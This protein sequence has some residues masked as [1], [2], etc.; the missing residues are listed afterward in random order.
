MKQGVRWIADGIRRDAD[1]LVGATIWQ[2]TSTPVTNHDI[3]GEQIYASTD[4]S[5]IAFMRDL[6][7]YGEASELWVC[8]LPTK[9]VT[10]VSEAV[11]GFA[12]TPFLDNLYYFFDSLCLRWKEIPADGHGLPSEVRGIPNV[13]RRK[14]EGAVLLASAEWTQPVG[15]EFLMYLRNLG[16]KEARKVRLTL[17]NRQ[18]A[19]GD[20][21]AEGFV[22]R[23]PPQSEF[24]TRLPM[25]S[26]LKGWPPVLE[27]VSE[28]TQI[29]N[30]S[31]RE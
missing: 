20:I 31:T 23:I 18:E 13:L 22:E 24:I 9:R 11:G 19:G 6:S 12:S 2:L 17:R 16:R 4:G 7:P 25:K 30:P 21:I 3:Y 27:A 5:R 26:S 10:R 28:N 8:D 29:L 1:G 15:K 14:H